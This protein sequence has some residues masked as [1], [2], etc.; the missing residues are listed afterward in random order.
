MSRAGLPAAAERCARALPEEQRLCLLAEGVGRCGAVR[1]A[2]TSQS[3][4]WLRANRALRPA[5]W[6][7]TGRGAGLLFDS[8]ADVGFSAG[9]L[10]ADAALPDLR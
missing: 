4:H 1:D 9:W 3:A 5:L 7:A 10:A 6:H 8:S 2:G